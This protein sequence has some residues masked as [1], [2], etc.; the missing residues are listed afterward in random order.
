MTDKNKLL[1]FLFLALLILLPRSAFAFLGT[2][3]F[4]Y[5]STA[6]GGV[7][8]ASKQFIRYLSNIF[9]L[10]V[11]TMFLLITS[12][13]LLEWIISNPQWLTIQENQMVQAG[14]L[15]TSGI[16]NMFLI[17]VFILLAFGYILKIETFATKKALIR[18]I[19]VAF[20]MNFSLV[21]IGMSVDIVNVAYNTILSG[22]KNLTLQV[23]EG[24]VMGI[25]GVISNFLTWYA[26]HAASSLIPLVH[27][28]PLQVGVLVTIGTVFL[29]NIVMTFFQIISALL[30]SGVFFILVFLFMARVFII[31]LLAILAPL[32][33]LCW[34]LPQTQRWWGEWLTHFTQWLT[35]GVEKLFFLVLG[36]RAVSILMPDVAP[37]PFGLTW[38]AGIDKVFIYY[39]AL[40]I[41]LVIVLWMNKKTMPAFAEFLIEQTKALA[42]NMWTQGI[43]PFTGIIRERIRWALARQ[44]R[45]EEEAERR[46]EEIT[47]REKP[48]LWLGKQ[49]A[50]PI[51]WAERQI[52]GLTPE[53]MV[54]KEIENRANQ[55]AEKFRKDI[56]AALEVHPINKLNEVGKIALGLYLAKQR[57]E[58]GFDKLTTEQQRDWVRLTARLS[59]NK[60]I[61]VV[62]HKRELIDDEEVGPLIKGILVQKE[63]EDKDVQELIRKGVKIEGENIRE[64]LKTDEG[65]AKIIREAAHKKA[66]EALKNEDIAILS[67]E[68]L[69]SQ[70]FQEMVTKY[71]SFGFIR[72][73]GE[74]RGVDYIDKIQDRAEEIGLEEIAKTNPTL[75]RA[76]YTPAGSLL[77]RTWRGK[78]ITRGKLKKKTYKDLIEH[79]KNLAPRSE[80]HKMIMEKFEAL[81][82]KGVSEKEAIRKAYAGVTVSYA[83][84]KL[85]EA[86]RSGDQSK[87]KY[88]SEM[89]GHALTKAQKGQEVAILKWE[90]EKE[91]G[92]MTKTAINNL[93]RNQNKI[94]K[95][96]HSLSQAPL[97]L[98]YEK[99]LQEIEEAKE[100]IKRGGPKE[101]IRA[102]ERKIEDLK[103]ILESLRKK[104]EVDP[105]L[106]SIAEELKK[107]RKEEKK[108]IIKNAQIL[109]LEKTS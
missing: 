88:F 16:A 80:R 96:T 20:L 94:I 107:L 66:I 68:T 74:E 77:M 48:G 42:A 100:T 46:G 17:L 12:G 99:T 32:A 33:F 14:F 23:I 83:K 25:W 11:T 60:L 34:I 37:I 64:L 105:K 58:E 40:W 28:L 36:F 70:K 89:L 73:L 103:K 90:I 41:Y 61:D 79:C 55:L 51:R 21:F 9:F 7:E 87:I 91:G 78:V 52:S 71:R 97:L 57:G 22:N 19:I 18:L 38:F 5:T 47:L 101:I 82:E 109:S 67:K 39:F 56:T 13:S 49:M 108:E 72:R 8:E 75:L 45:E 53:I 85:A 106:K 98:E 30:I 6:L 84:R 4:D 10:Y 76:P 26:L 1:F 102:T 3:L 104:I 95:L 24:L 50:K 27:S 29:P 35:L 81:K 31:Q 54:E 92:V 59:P 65:R 62:K 86:K 43:Q 63:I 69:D 2:S 93:I 44:K 15:F